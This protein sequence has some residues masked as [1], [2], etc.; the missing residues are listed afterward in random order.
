VSLREKLIAEFKSA[1]EPVTLEPSSG[2]IFEVRVGDKIA[3]SNREAG[4]FPN[5]AD[6]AA[7]KQQIRQ[8]SGG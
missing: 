6:V 3:F 8:Q 1:I 5:D 4:R 2:G 7:I